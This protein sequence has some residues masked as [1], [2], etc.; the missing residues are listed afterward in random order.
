MHI[1]Q[2]SAVALAATC[3]LLSTAGCAVAGTSGNSSGSEAS[4]D[5]PIK[6][7][8]IGALSGG[9]A[10]MGEPGGNGMSLAVSEIN[11][12]GGIAGRQLELIAIDDKA[13]PATSATAA[14]KLVSEDGVVAVIGG[15]NSG[16]VKANNVI[17]AGAGVPQLIAIGSEDTLIDPSNENFGLTFRTTENNSYDVGAIASLFES[18]GYRSICILA[19]TTAYGE[20]GIASIKRVFGARGLEIHS[21]QQHP[22]N[23]TDLTSQTLSLRDA[24]C[25]S[26]Y[27]FSLAPD[28]ALFFKTMQQIGW[29]VPVVGGR[30]LAGA[31]FISLGGTAA[32]GLIVPGVVD[33]NKAEGAAFIKAYDTKYGAEGDPTHSYSALGYDSIQLLAAALESTGGAGGDKLAKAL[34][35]TKLTDGATG[36]KGSSLSFNGDK[37]EAPSENYVVF[38]ELRD[39][40]YQ[41]LTSDVESGQ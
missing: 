35:A 4:I 5:G 27:L 3:L 33:P 22:V 24:G 39:G 2:K 9:S 26:I 32:E 31:S 40:T 16:T 41:F 36:K 29:D 8:Y 30:G 15:P 21:V 20:G 23:A 1:L 12:A 6:I 10:Y 28:G 13:D 11:E 25:D 34:E 14:Q 37:H 17:I 7:G 18:E 19:D 38:Y